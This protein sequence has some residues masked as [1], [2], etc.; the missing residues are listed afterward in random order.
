VQTL[1]LSHLKNF[2]VKETQQL[3][4]EHPSLTDLT[5]HNHVDMTAPILQKLWVSLQ[6]CRS[7]ERF[8]L[9]GDTPAVPHDVA[10]AAFDHMY[11]NQRRRLQKLTKQKPLPR[12]R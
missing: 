7:V 9:I 10:K 1:T 3:L 5:I 8:T 4:E 11:T 2:Y 6:R 12:K